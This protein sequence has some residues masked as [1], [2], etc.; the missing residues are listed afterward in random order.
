MKNK[1]LFSVF[2]FALSASSIRTND[3]CSGFAPHNDRYIPV[4][5]ND[6]VTTGISESDFNSVLDKVESLY[7]SI[8]QEKGGTF[9]INRLWTNGTVNASA[10]QIGETWV[11][12]MYGGL[13]RHELMTADGFL[14]V[15][16]HE[17]GH[18]LA[19]NPKYSS[20]FGGS[21]WAS[22]EGQSD[23]FGTTKCLKRVYSSMSDEELAQFKGNDPIAKTNCSKI[24][25]ETRDQLICERSAIAG[26]VLGNVLAELG[27][28]AEVKLETPTDAVYSGIYQYHP[29]AQ[30]RLDT[31]FQGSLCSI[32]FGQDFS[33]SDQVTG[34]CSVETGFEN[35]LRPKCWF[36]PS[37]A[38]Y[39]FEFESSIKSKEIYY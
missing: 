5:R 39:N 31:Y 30:C 9:E 3:L 29:R 34:A 33:D 28:Q 17:L 20:Y 38:A 23:Y 21:S 6:E 37:A 2:T 10:E 22:V 27:G 24:Y 13:A 11:I 32:P 8:I 15:A 16:C 19:G 26:I 14:L 25:S 18:H 7:T 36:N 35:G 1:L 4:S 12:N